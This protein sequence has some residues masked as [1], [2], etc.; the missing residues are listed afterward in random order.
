MKMMVRITGD[1]LRLQQYNVRNIRL[2]AI[3]VHCVTSSNAHC[4]D[5]CVCA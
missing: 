2:L 1:F 5:V 4:S 3:A